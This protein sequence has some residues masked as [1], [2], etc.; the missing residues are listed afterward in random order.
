VTARLAHSVTGAHN[1]ATV[2]LSGSLGTT[3]EMWAPQID[4]LSKRHRVLAIDHS[5]HGDSEVATPP[6]Q[7]S[8]LGADVLALLD[9]LGV[10]RFSFVGL[11]LG[12]MV[13][14]WIAADA[15]ARVE[16]LVVICSSARLDAAD[17]WRQR[18]A[19]VRGRGMAA[20]AD[21]VV[22]R[23]FTP[24]Y[25]KGNPEVVEHHRSMLVATPVE[26]YAGC[27]EALTD[28][29]L[30]DRLP[31]ITA[32]TLVIGARQDTAIP[33]AHSEAIAATVTDARLEV[34]DSAAHL[35]SVEQ[36]TVVTRLINMHLDGE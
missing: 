21:A 25:A 20:I 31:A 35:A 30:R 13:G 22:D 36:P 6:Y 26:G 12:G 3:R 9:G 29:D 19:T 28:F 24:S 7:M 27:C 33:P 1:A 23:W 4:E 8:D 15:P 18:A 2:V 17:A 5:G 16:R 14:M 34:L 10:D 11:S 32:P